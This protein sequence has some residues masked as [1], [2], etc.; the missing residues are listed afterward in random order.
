MGDESPRP[1]VGSFPYGFSD[2]NRTIRRLEKE[3]WTS[4]RWTGMPR[5][6]LAVMANET[7]EAIYMDDYG[8]ILPDGTANS[9]PVS[10]HECP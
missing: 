4:I 8:N 5:P 6:E 10:Q 2:Q 9:G 3:G 7:G 1:V